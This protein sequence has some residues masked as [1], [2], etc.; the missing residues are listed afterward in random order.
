MKKIVIF[1]T[2]EIAEL[3]YF[4]MKNDDFCNFD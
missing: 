2:G 3:A 1:G 4:Y